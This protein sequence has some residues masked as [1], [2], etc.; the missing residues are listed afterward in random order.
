MWIKFGLLGLGVFVAIYVI[1]F[2]DIW[3]RRNR[4]RICDL[5]AFGG[6]AFLLGNFAVIAS[7][8]SWPFGAWEKGI[9]IF[10]LIAMAYPPGW[11]YSPQRPAAPATES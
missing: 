4:G 9:L 6:G 1:L 3:R 7:V 11:R 8:Y 10:A 5:L 2:R